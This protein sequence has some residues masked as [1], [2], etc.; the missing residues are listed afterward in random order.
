MKY[1]QAI[2]LF[3]VLVLSFTSIHALDYDFPI[4]PEIITAFIPDYEPEFTITLED[5][6]FYIEE[7]EYI[8]IDFKIE[9]NGYKNGFVKIQFDDTDEDYEDY[10]TINK[11]SDLIEV[12][13]NSETTVRF[14]LYID[15]VPSDEYDLRFDI[16]TYYYDNSGDYKELDN[17]Y[18]IVELNIDDFE[19]IDVRLDDS[20]ICYGSDL[21]VKRQLIFYND[22]STKYYIDPEVESNEDLWPQVKSDIIEIPRDDDT[23]VEILFRKVPEIGRYQ[24]EIDQYLYKSKIYENKQRFKKTID[25]Y[26]ENCEEYNTNFYINTKIQNIKTNDKV[27]YNYT[28]YNNSESDMPVFFSGYSSD[29]SIA[30][31]FTNETLLAS[32]RHSYTGS[33]YVLTS[34][35]TPSGVKTITLRAETPYTTFERTVQIN[36]LK[37]NLNIEVSPIDVALGLKATQAITIENNT[38]S[39]VVLSLATDAQSDDLVLLSENIVRIGNGLKKTIYAEITPRSIGSKSYDLIVSGTVNKTKTVYYSSNYEVH[40]VEFVASYPSKLN[41]TA[42][43]WETMEVSLT[44]PY[45]FEATIKLRLSNSEDLTSK[46]ST[47]ILKPKQSRTVGVQYIVN[48]NITNIRTSLEVNTD[49]SA[50]TYL[51]NIA[52][53]PNPNLTLPLELKEFDGVVT[54][55]NG[56]ESTNTIKVF[57]PNNYPISSAKITVLDNEDNVLGETIFDILALE[58][59]EVEFTF[60][61]NSENDTTGRILINAD[62]SEN[63]LDVIYTKSG[64]FESGLFNLG[65]GGTISIILG[66]LIIIL[67]VL[68][69]TLKKPTSPSI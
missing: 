23:R 11:T 20:V 60:T 40:D 24:L 49:I 8:N 66:A 1:L 59:K 12:E 41:A 68:Y 42:N 45:N 21:P 33:F 48:K 54:Y 10:F 30:V 46:Y 29:Q 53:T 16:L 32:A 17:D 5:D 15:N 58:E 6:S 22:T 2:L 18:E 9:N 14:K 28:F 57:N 34:E 26:V 51:V 47:V 35:D 7:D 64:F 25:V 13:G 52:V 55:R 69:F 43:K 39:D 62:S 36:V 65:V 63:A 56:S 19:D 50:N 27:T 4:N 38:G 3:T 31:V 61:L 44:N 67:I 37:N